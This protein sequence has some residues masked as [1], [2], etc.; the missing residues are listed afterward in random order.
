MSI[1][2]FKKFNLLLN[3]SGSINSLG[4]L[5]F[6]VIIF[7]FSACRKEQKPIIFTGKLLLSKKYPV[8]LANRFIEIYQ[9]GNSSAIGLS[10]GSSS[11]TST[12]STTVDGNFNLQ[13]RPGTASLL[14]FS[15]ASNA[16]LT[17]SSRDGIFPGFSRQYFPDSAYDPTKPIY[18][19]KIIDTVIIKANLTVPLISTDTIG[20][21]TTTI[22]GS[23]DK[24]YTGNNALQGSIIPIDTI[25]NMLFTEYTGIQK[26]FRNTLNAGKKTTYAAGYT[27]N[28]NWY[29]YPPNVSKEDEHKLEIIFYYIP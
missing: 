27:I 9:G 3:I 19:G 16:P 5:L 17:L 11:S 12:G 22:D 24:I 10:S 8:P 23:L 4:C 1:Y 29:I 28:S 6:F 21:Q 14:F 13:F 2:F 26:K 15:G 7:L 18:I 25:Y 20:L